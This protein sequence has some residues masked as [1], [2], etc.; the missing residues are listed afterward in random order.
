M[1]PGCAEECAAVTDQ[2]QEIIKTTTVDA[3]RLA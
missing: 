3:H 2:L 1:A